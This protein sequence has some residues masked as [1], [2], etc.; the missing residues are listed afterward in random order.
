M[1]LGNARKGEPVRIKRAELATILAALRH[2]Q[3]ALEAN[4][5]HPPA[6]LFDTA[7]EAGRFLR[8]NTR[9]IDEICARLNTE[10]SLL[11]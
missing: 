3:N 2:W 11:L 8:L 4:G 6:D 9:Q 5:G 10:R 7:T 1:Y